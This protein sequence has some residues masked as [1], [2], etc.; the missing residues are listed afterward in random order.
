MIHKYIFSFIHTSSVLSYIVLKRTKKALLS[1]FLVVISW[2][3]AS[4]GIKSGRGDKNVLLG[5]KGLN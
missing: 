3:G 2:P 1:L 4:G 5:R